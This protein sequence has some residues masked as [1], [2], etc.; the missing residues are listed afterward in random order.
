MMSGFSL[1]DVHA[2]AYALLKGNESLA[3]NGWRVLDH[4]GERDVP[5]YVVIESSGGSDISL[6]DR[7][8]LLVE[9]ELDFWS[10]KRGYKFLLEAM[11]E[12]YNALHMRSI[13]FVDGVYA[14]RTHVRFVHVTRDEDGIKRHGIMRV[15]AITFTAT[16]VAVVDDG[17][18]FLEIPEES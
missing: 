14:V 2:G 13:L 18:R 6:K 10:D 4:V 12:V 9:L 17:N 3:S 8:G 11:K 16:G 7:G 15:E 5:P 1:A